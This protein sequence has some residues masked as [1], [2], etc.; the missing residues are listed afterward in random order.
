MEFIETFDLSSTNATFFGGENLTA[1]L[2]AVIA[3]D[4][5]IIDGFDEA[6]DSE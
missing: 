5:V 4:A 2:D 1:L 3:G 6:D